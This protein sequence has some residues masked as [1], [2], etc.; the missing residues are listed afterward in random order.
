MTLS[1][2]DI[3]DALYTALS[4]LVINVSTGTTAQRPF[5]MLGRFAGEV[6][7]KE[8]REVCSQYPALLLAFAGE[9]S[10]RTVRTLAGDAEDRGT[11]SWV[12]YVCVEDP[13][14]I[15][16]ATVGTVDRP[17]GMRL[18]DAALGVLNGL[19]IPGTWMNQR[20]RTA[21]AREVLIRRGTVYVWAIAFDV[22]RA[23]PQVTP[24]D[25]SVDLEEIAGD[26]NLEDTLNDD[27]PGNPVVQ[28]VADTAE[29]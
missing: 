8:L 20:L 26:V 2:A 1:L 29:A 27:N 9:Q 19:L 28:F 13:A 22:M 16:D 10:V 14:A 6:D 11:S 25:T 3:D 24:A 4:A 5:A 7:D 12:V 21:G 17:G 23:L 15:D 18:V